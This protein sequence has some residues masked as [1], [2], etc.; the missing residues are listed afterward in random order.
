[1]FHAGFVD[2]ISP[3]GPLV[4][5]ELLGRDYPNTKAYSGGKFRDTGL[6]IKHISVPG[7]VMTFTVSFGDVS[8][9]S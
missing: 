3:D 9:S 4:K 6:T 8:S 7:D 2:G 5:G 1:L